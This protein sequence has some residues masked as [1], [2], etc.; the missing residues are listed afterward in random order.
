MKTL[1]GIPCFETVYTDFMKSMLDVEKPEGACY[2]VVKNSLVY[3]AR[4]IIALNAIGCGF[5]RVAWFDSDMKIPTDAMVQMSRDMD[6]GAEFVIGIYFTRTDPIRPVL[7]SELWWDWKNGELDTGAKTFFEYPADSLFECKAVGFGCAM[8]SVDLLKRVHDHF[9]LPFSPLHGL[10]ED[11]SFCWRVSQLG[12]PIY[13]D[14]RVKCGH[15]G[16]VAYDEEM[17]RRLH[18]IAP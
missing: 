8:V 3:D 15:I 9:G 2:T 5:D 7:C 12:V 17:Y 4:N 16:A 10:G 18:P 13:C 1:I 14:S 11:Y 6:N